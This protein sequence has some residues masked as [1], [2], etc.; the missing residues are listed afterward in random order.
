MF[1]GAKHVDSIWYFLDIYRLPTLT[2]YWFFLSIVRI[3]SNK[4]QF[5]FFLNLLHINCVTVASLSPQF[6]C[7][8]TRARQLFSEQLQKLAAFIYKTIFI[9]PS[10]IK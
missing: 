5:D 7:W 2:F 6:Q 10:I 4:L 3:R 8:L 1:F 9:C